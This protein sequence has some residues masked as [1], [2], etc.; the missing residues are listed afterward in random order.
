MLSNSGLPARALVL[1]ALLLTVGC[2]SS[3][4]E[5][6]FGD[7][8]RVDVTEDVALDGQVLRVP[9]E[10]AGGCAEHRFGP[11]T[12]FEEGSARIW[13]VHDD[14]GDGCEALVTETV[15]VRLSSADTAPPRIDLVVP[16]GDGEATIRLR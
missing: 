14:G 1:L 13:L 11:F 5:V 2:D 4:I 8:Y 10:Y 7:P 15:V 16:T 9:V 6:D 3:G 12:A